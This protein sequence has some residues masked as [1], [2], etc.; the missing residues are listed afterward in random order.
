[1][2]ADGFRKVASVDVP[3]AAET[4]KSTTQTKPYDAAGE[5]FETVPVDQVKLGDVILV[6]PGETVPV[7]GEL[8]S[9]AKCMRARA[10]CR[11]RS[12]DRPR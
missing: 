10:C 11:V 5:H 4:N 6:L 8:L 3:N 1:M 2:T 7:D 12:T 9:G